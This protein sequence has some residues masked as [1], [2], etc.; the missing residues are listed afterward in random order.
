VIPLDP[1]GSV[2]F[3]AGPREIVTLRIR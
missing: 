2:P 1:D 3:R